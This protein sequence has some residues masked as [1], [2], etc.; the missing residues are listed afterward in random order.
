[1]ALAAERAS[2][3]GLAFEAG[4]AFRQNDARQH[5]RRPDVR[6]AAQ[7]DGVVE[8]STLDADD[9]VGAAALVPETRAAVAAEEALERVAG[10]RRPGPHA[11]RAARDAEGG[12]HRRGGDAD[13]RARLL[14]A[15]AAVADVDGDEVAVELIADRAALA[16][17]ETHGVRTGFAHWVT[18]AAMPE[19]NDARRCERGLSVTMPVVQIGHVWVCVLQRLVAMGMRVGLHDLAVLGRV[20]VPVVLVV[21]MAM[22]VDLGRVYV[23]V[24]VARA[25]HD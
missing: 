2:S 21:D 24:R 20:R 8:R 12:A 14:P 13:G 17:T 23:Q 15:L 18:S 9:G 25:Q 1:M 7:V 22:I 4:A 11:R 3:F 16:A 6:R 5:A 19:S 10:V